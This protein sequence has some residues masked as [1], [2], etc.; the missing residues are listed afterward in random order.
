MLM[1]RT[2]LQNYPGVLDM[3]IT[4]EEKWQKEMKPHLSKC[5]NL[6]YWAE[7]ISAVVVIRVLRQS[8]RTHIKVYF[9][10]GKRIGYCLLCD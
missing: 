1:R 9:L 4:F 2:Q 10:F 8:K 6:L 3:S 5:I 7:R